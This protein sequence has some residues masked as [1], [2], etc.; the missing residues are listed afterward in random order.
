[1]QPPVLS[2][3]NQINNCLYDKQ[4]PHAFIGANNLPQIGK[5][6]NWLAT[7]N[8]EITFIF[9]ETLDFKRI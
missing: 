6:I 1:M 8:L 3:N 4:L 2:I 7:G 5:N 9:R